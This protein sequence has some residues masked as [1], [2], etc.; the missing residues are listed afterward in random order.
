MLLLDQTDDI[1][2]ETIQIR[3]GHFVF[4]EPGAAPGRRPGDF[5]SGLGDDGNI[6][7][8][9]AGDA[10]RPVQDFPVTPNGDRPIRLKP[11]DLHARK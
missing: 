1:G 8:E 4:N 7:G 10:V 11:V 9:R 5:R 6:Q 2:V 3:L